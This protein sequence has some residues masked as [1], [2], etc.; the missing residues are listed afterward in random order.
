MAIPMEPNELEK[1]IAE[2]PRWHYMFEFG[3]GLRTPVPDQGM[4]NRHEQ[5]R[6]YFFEPLVRLTGG[7]L[8]GHRVLDLGCNAGFWSLN[9]LDSGAD[10]V[11]GVDARQTYIEQARLVFEA[12]EADPGHREHETSATRLDNGGRFSR[13][14]TPTVPP[15]EGARQ[16]NTRISPMSGGGVSYRLCK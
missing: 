3:G 5:R 2:F 14:H 9:A 12:K 13:Y 15:V 1:R 6:R 16:G 10:F 4:V 7:S 11:L 8:S